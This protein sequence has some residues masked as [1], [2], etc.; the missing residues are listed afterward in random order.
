MYGKYCPWRLGSLEFA[1]QAKK[2]CTFARNIFIMW[3]FIILSFGLALSLYGFKKSLQEKKR[4]RKSH[5]RRNNR[6]ISVNGCECHDEEMTEEEMIA[7]DY[8]YYQ[9]RE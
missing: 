6:T 1:E 8:Y 9:D 2:V 5:P 7:E 3:T 4:P